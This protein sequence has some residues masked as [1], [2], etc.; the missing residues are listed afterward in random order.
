M[1]KNKKETA[2]SGQV[3]PKRASPTTRKKKEQQKTIENKNINDLFP[4]KGGRHQETM[5]TRG[6]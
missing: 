3:K 4:N 1:A 2:K 5:A 6:T